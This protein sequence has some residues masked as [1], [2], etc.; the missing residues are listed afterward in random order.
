MPFTA[1]RDFK[2]DPRLIVRGE[3]VHYWN[4]RGERILDGSSGLFCSAAGHGRPEIAE[5]VAKQLLEMDFAAPF[6][7]GHPAA[8][9]VARRVAALTPGDLN[10]VFFVNSG[11]E[12]VD[13]ALKIALAYASAR[14]EGRRQ[15]F[16]SRERAYHGVNV[17]GTSLSGIMKNREAFGAL[18]PGV[19]H[20]RHTWLPEN[21]FT[22][23]QPA[24]GAELAEDLQRIAELVGGN[25]IAAC[26]IEPIA[27]S[28]GILVPPK[29]YLERLRE[30]CDANGIL[31][32]FDE[33]ICGFGRTGKAFAAQSFGVTPDM[34]TM[35][36]ALTNAA[37][38]MGAVAIR[39]DIYDTVVD[40][41]P[42]QSVELFHGYTYSAHPAACAA[43][44]A[45]LDIY[46][47]ENLFERAAEMSPYFLDSIFAL[48][49]MPGVT[50]IRGYGMIAG[51]DIAPGPVPGMRGYEATKRLFRAGL[52]VKFT[53][54]CALV[55][56]PLVAGKSDI[57][58]IC[59]ILR[60]VLGGME[61]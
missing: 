49:D 13:T 30:I 31:L 5:A 17:G 59:S 32:V 44:L 23:G 57:D 36:K 37:Q 9:E 39:D 48:E 41:A 18:M 11:S 50:D 45:T 35:A 43:A 38:P 33:V 34:I 4:H 47:R 54:D 27:G 20:M 26:F 56:P 40:A 19:V 46:E 53:G 42:G 22:K 16:V 61:E 55:A 29:G 3:G 12:A 21:R 6:Q 1:N 58:E 52:H 14:G 25:T 7:M 28:T 51:I 2:A 8:F 60:E 24:K 15:R 10:H